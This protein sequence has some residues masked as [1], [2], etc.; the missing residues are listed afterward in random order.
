MWNLT[1]SLGKSSVYDNE[2]RLSAWSFRVG[3]DTCVEHRHSLAA[4]YV[5]LI[6]TTV[7]T[8]DWSFP[9]MSNPF[10]QWESSKMVYGKRFPTCRFIVF[11]KNSLFRLFKKDQVND[12][13]SFVVWQTIRKRRVCVHSATIYYCVI[14]I[15]TW[16]KK[17]NS[18]FDDIYIIKL[19]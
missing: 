6:F 14:D 4:K 1:G 16:C 17:L 10:R 3:V 12:M 9:L 15:C 8:L 13:V 2:I 19:L 11:S 18:V 7:D 5:G